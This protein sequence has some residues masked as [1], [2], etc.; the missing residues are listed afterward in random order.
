M[1]SHDDDDGDVLEHDDGEGW[2]WP[3]ALDLEVMGWL[4]LSHS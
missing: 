1:A 2:E 3:W 4:I